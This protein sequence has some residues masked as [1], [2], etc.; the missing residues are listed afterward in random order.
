MMPAN[1]GARGAQTLALA[2]ACAAVW[3]LAARS[4]H[5]SLAQARAELAGAVN[6]ISAHETDY[7]PSA[8][9]PAKA[10]LDLAD[11]EKR[12]RDL[13][14]VSGDAAKVY[15]ALGVVAGSCNVRVDRIE[16]VRSGV[17]E[18]RSSRQAAKPGA[19]AVSAE[20]THYVIEATGQYADI[21]RFVKALERDLG[22]TRVVSLR[23]SPAPVTP[24]APPAISASIETSHYKLTAG[25]E[26]GK[27]ATA[28]TEHKTEHKK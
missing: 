7:P 12:V 27:D 24:G 20:S 3:Y 13:T 6:E 8:G 5:V 19:F 2:A 15:E 1:P 18:P 9:D 11:R 16:P 14:R 26:P 28:Q 17:R 22:L 23:L 4:L 21:A 25:T 10:M